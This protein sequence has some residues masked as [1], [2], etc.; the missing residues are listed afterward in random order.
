MIRDFHNKTLIGASP[1]VDNFFLMK[2]PVPIFSIA[3]LYMLTILVI[4]P[5]FM[6]NREPFQINK[7]IIVYNLIQI[8]FSGYIASLVSTRFKKNGAYLKV[9]LISRRA[10]NVFVGTRQT[11]KC[12][13]YL[14]TRLCIFNE[15]FLSSTSSSF[16]SFGIV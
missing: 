3:L 11:R 14:F 12:Q 16:S 7:V 10:R 2:S 15:R 8:L 1:E 9:V 4:G 6:K 5:R 13:V